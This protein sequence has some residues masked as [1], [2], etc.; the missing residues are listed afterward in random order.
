MKHPDDQADVCSYDDLSVA[1]DL[2]GNVTLE[3]PTCGFIPIP[4][5]APTLSDLTN[6]AMIHLSE[7][8]PYT[9]TL[10]SPSSRQATSTEA[11]RDVS[12]GADADDFWALIALLGP[13]GAGGDLE[14]FA[15]GLAALD[16]QQLLA[17][18]EQLMAAA[19]ELDTPEHASQTVFDLDEPVHSVPSAM[20]SDEFW[21]VRLA[22]VAAGRDFWSAVLADPARLAGSWPVQDARLILDAPAA[23]YNRVTGRR[24]FPSPHL[25][26]TTRT[27]RTAVPTA[28]AAKSGA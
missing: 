5:K 8:H 14:A 25:S 10:P 26:G 23:A 9:L 12:A 11:A 22:V 24:R 28:G 16:E 20:S 6:A 19:A 21:A 4:S 18:G 17:F 3:C 2:V 15:S 7:Q 13:D 27:Q 1:A